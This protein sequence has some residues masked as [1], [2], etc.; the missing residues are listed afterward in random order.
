MCPN[1]TFVGRYQIPDMPVRQD[2]RG[3]VLYDANSGAA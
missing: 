1:L 3:D 2:A